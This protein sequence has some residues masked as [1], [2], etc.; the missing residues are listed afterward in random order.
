M[1]LKQLQSDMIIAMK[2]GEKERKEVLSTLI[3]AIK[4]AG[5]DNKC[6]ESIPENLINSVLLKEEKIVKEQINTCPK[7]RENLLKKY[8]FNLSI[9]QEYTPKLEKDPVKL[10]AMIL[11]ILKNNNIELL[12]ANRGKAMKIIMQQLKNSADLSIVN[13]IMIEI[14]A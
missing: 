12:K 7:D 5:I 1:T 8:A 4:K 2:Q 11:G 10:K 14:F 3:S 6:R 9:I 13:K